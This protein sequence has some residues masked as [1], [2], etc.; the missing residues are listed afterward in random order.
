MSDILNQSDEDFL[1][2]PYPTEEET[3]VEEPVQ[4]EEQVEEVVEEESEVVEEE[5]SEDTDEDA[6]ASSNQVEEDSD[7]ETTD[8]ETEEEP[9]KEKETEVVD[10]GLDY[11]TEY[12]KI[13]K[14]FKANG[15]EIKVDSVDEAI[16]LMQMGANYSKK[17]A[18]LKP[19]LK[20]LRMLEDNGLMDE[21]KLS[22]LIDLEKR[23][24]QA[25]NKLV[26]DSGIDPLDIDVNDS[27]E[28]KPSSYTVDDKEL[29]LDAVLEEISSTSAYSRTIDVVS[30]KWDATSKKVLLSNPTIIKVINEHIDQGIYD[31]ITS[32]M[33]KERM[34]GRLT[35]LSDLEAYKE[36]GDMLHAQGK[37]GVAPQAQQAKKIV[38]PKPKASEDPSLVARKKAAG[39]TQSKPSTSKSSNDDFNPLAL[40]DS[41]FEKMFANQKF[42]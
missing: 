18:S 26:K 29:E 9:V 5:E 40:D 20:V 37:F 31:Q 27:T 30:N 39:L 12:E 8:T 21:A 17:M 4:E 11:K 25:I 33:D 38:K 10:T 22:F 1:K 28:Y 14:P 16:Q 32:V 2:A 34:L 41:E 3:E 24:P 35:G 23:K 13:L 42:R 15:K 7:D 19:G 6:P 36:V